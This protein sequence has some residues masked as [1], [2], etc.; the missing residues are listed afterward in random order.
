MGYT[1]GQ[2][3]RAK[4]DTV[5]PRLRKVVERAIEIT[6]QDFVV[7]CGVRAQREQYQ[8]YAKGRH[9][10]ELRAAGVPLDIL[11]Q[12]GE[13]KVTWTLHSRHCPDTKTG[14]SNAVDLCPFPIDW[15]HLAKFDAVSRAMRQAAREIGVSIRWGADWDDDG[16]SREKGESDSPHFE[17]ARRA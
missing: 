1:L 15:N 6:E 16:K 10:A 14:L 3:S 7:L 17:L 8:L 12:P 13:P 4:L 11:A 5:D 2:A 9:V